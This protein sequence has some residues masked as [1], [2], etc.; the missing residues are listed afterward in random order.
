MISTTTLPPF[1]RT[2][3]HTVVPNSILDGERGLLYWPSIFVEGVGL[4]GATCT[5]THTHTPSL[6]EVVFLLSLLCICTFLLT[7]TALG[8][9]F[10][11][12]A[13]SSLSFPS[14]FFFLSLF[15]LLQ[16]R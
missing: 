12:S 11:G 8:F 2:L 7:L 13:V 6:V 3:T 5:T 16:G 15:Q 14:L 4:K 10:F 9:F 1:P